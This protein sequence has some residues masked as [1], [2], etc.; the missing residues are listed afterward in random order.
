VLQS[1]AASLNPW[2]SAFQVIAEP[3]V[4]TGDNGKRERRERVLAIMEK[5]GLPAEAARRRSS[6][7]SG[8]Q[9]QRLALARA[10]M[11]NPKIIILDESV[12]GLDVALQA[13]MINL[14]LDLQASLGISY[15]FI[16]HDMRLAA[17]FSD[18][19]AV[20]HAGKVVEC[21]SV[22]DVIGQPQH[23]H[24]KQLLTAVSHKLRM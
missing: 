19:M 17:H 21:G 4:I 24:T 12:S 15:I 13:H 6:E 22:R 8:G 14:L 7:F 2:F 11:I 1:S 3:L 5:V 16:S 18:Q 20:M 9:R 10:L 23:D